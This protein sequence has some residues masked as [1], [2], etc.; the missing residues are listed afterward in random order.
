MCVRNLQACWHVA[1][2]LARGRGG[3]EAAH[4][5]EVGAR[6]AG[7]NSHAS[8][9][10]ANRWQTGPNRPPPAATWCSEGDHPSEPGKVAPRPLLPPA[11]DTWLPTCPRALVPSSPSPQLRASFE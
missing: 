5:P 2:H 3:R 8:D 1:A 7:M 4:H 9:H 10:V 11:S 6:R